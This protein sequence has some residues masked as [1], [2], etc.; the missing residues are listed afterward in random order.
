MAVLSW[1]LLWYSPHN[2]RALASF[3]RISFAR[4]IRVSMACTTRATLSPMGQCWLPAASGP[5]RPPRVR[6]WPRR[7][8]WRRSTPKRW[9]SGSPPSW[10]ATAS[11]RRSSPRGFYAALRGLSPTC[12]GIPNPG[13]NSNLAGRPSAGC[14]SGCR[15]PSSS[16]CLPYAWQRA[17][18]KS[19]NLTKTG[20]TPRRNPAWCSPT[21]NAGRSSPSSRRTSALRRKCRSPSPSNSGW[22][23][24]LSVTSSWTPGAAAWRN[25]KMT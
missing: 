24:R 23:W 7:D 20:T 10:S 21:S 18:A 15:S 9:P 5:R 22:S 19:K 14:G 25:G 17:S 13:V 16:A 2:Q 6:R 11:H 12:S 4:G 1:A 8:S 3:S